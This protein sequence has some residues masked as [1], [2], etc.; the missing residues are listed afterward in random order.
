MHSFAPR[1]AKQDEHFVNERCFFLHCT[2]RISST[3]ILPV[4]MG[5]VTVCW[6]C[7]C[8]CLNRFVR[9][10]NDIL[11]FNSLYFIFFVSLPPSTD[12]L[13]YQR[14]A[15]IFYTFC[16]VLI[17]FIFFFHLLFNGYFHVLHFFHYFR[18]HC[19]YTFNGIHIAQ[20]ILYI[21]VVIWAA[22]FMHSIILSPSFFI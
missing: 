14:E 18:L 21:L 3:E 13:L 19:A 8:C 12:W 7:C 9:E 16:F 15:W 5:I 4:Q 11:F 1:N 2:W 20:C 6:Y 10:Y 17:Y 22:C